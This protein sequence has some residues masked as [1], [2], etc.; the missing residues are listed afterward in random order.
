MKKLFTVLLAILFTFS[1]TSENLAQ[2][3][4]SSFHFKTKSYS[5]YKL[6]KSTY[7]SNTYKAPK[8]KSYT[9]KS[10]SLPKS[11]YKS[12][13]TTY[14]V[15]ENYKTT[16][17]PKVKRSEAAKE[18]FLKQ[19]GYKK[20]PKGYEVDHIIPLSK[21]GQDDPSNMQLITKEAHKQKTA[22]ERKK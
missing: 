6:P 4:S 20:V 13:S 10:Y 12:G 1:L 7:K 3:K 21:G 14:F 2:K 11:T 19:K 16:G 17:M 8:L 9:P 15:G 18:K 5:N 22:S